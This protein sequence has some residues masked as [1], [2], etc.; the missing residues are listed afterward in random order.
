MAEAELRR[1]IGVGP[2]TPDGARRPGSGRRAEKGPICR[3]CGGSEGPIVDGVHLHPER[4]CRSQDRAFREALSL[5]S[6]TI[7]GLTHLHRPEAVEQVQR[8]F[9]WYW[10]K[11]WQDFDTWTEAW[12]A[13]E[14]Q[15]K[16]GAR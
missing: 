3:L 9:A 13:F 6:S 16:P 14:A 8:A 11:R 1:L 2:L 7:A 10:R 5:S 15:G 4:Q 12:E